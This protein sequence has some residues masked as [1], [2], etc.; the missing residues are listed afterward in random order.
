M[1]VEVTEQVYKLRGKRVWLAG[2]GLVGSA[3]AR[4][5]AVEP[6]AELITVPHAELDLRDQAATE[7]FVERV[8][9][10]VAIIAAARVGGIHAN[11]SAQGQFLYDNLM[12]SA[13]T[14][15]AARKF[16]V[17]KT[18]M[19]GSS[20][21]YPRDAKQPI[22]EDQLLTGPLEPTNEGY[23]M[24]KIAALEM[25]KM[26]RRQYGTSVISLM[27]TNL[28]GPNDN[29]DPAT[30][31]VLPAMIR[32]FHEAR[33]LDLDRVTI[34][35]TGR[36]RREFLHVDDLADATI[37]TLTV[38]DDDL[39]LNIGT[40]EDISISELASMIAEIV[41]WRGEITYDT[42]MPDGTPRKLLDVSR[43]QSLGWRPS[44]SLA[45]GI[46]ATY[47]WFVDNLDRAR[48]TGNPTA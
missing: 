48:G 37:H 25:A 21:I 27:P 5:L 44:I 11:R 8:R 43:L 46:K 12:I 35:G 13:N 6:I 22:D 7:R 15:E 29:F 40:G 28:Y 1:D 33:V 16:G 9:P 14:L 20:C 26:Y 4:R 10:D 18:V 42:S 30:S 36:P 34:W 19:L 45:E 41:G 31:H 23:A 17:G 2:Q 39:H 32:R 38:Y 24:A 47:A 3:V